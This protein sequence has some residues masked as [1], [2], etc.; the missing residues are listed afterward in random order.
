MGLINKF[1][2]IKMFKDFF[3]KNYSNSYWAIFNNLSSSAYYSSS[4]C[5]IFRYFRKLNCIK[6]L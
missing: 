1:V 6:F 5:L 4:L 2:I 3:F